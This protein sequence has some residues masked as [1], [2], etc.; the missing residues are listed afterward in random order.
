LGEIL[1]V[2]AYALTTNFFE[3]LAV[4]LGILCLCLILPRRLFLDLFV[5]RGIALAVL[6]L[7]YLMYLSSLF[8][9]KETYPSELLRWSPAA[10]VLLAA[11][12]YLLGNRAAVRRA[13][14]S[15]GDRALIFLYLSIPASMIA[16]LVVIYRAI[17]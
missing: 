1:V 4:L 13:L 14:E 5:A 17:A 8:V 12:A 6:G 11:G 16:L 3:S 7:A 15:F 10:A 9:T 2:Y